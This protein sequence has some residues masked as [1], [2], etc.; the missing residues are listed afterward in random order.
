MTETLTTCCC[1]FFLGA[2][3]MATL[4]LPREPAL[5]VFSLSCGR[6]RGSVDSMLGCLDSNLRPILSR[7]PAT[8]HIHHPQLRL[9]WLCVSFLCHHSVF[10]GCNSSGDGSD[11]MRS[12]KL[13]SA[14][15]DLLVTDWK[16][17]KVH[18]LCISYQL[19][20][21]CWLFISLQLCAVC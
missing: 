20:G 6:S 15:E 16:G 21:L 9:L 17:G 2:G 14:S 3:L 11:Y 8:V 5:S 7:M 1:Y 18:F 4:P 19:L 13:N 10:S 12:M